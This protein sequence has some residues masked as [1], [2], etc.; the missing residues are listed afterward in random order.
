[1]AEL[2]DAQIG[3]YREQGW[4]APIDIMSEAEAANILAELENAEARHP[5]HLHAENRNNAHL[6]FPFLSD[7]ALDPRIVDAAEQ[8]VGP[9]IS[10]WSTVL[11]IKE[12]SSGAFVSWHQDA[13]YM[14]LEPANFV[15]A[16]IALTPSTRE[17]G[18]VSVIPGTYLGRA[19]HQ[20]EYGDDNILTRGQTIGGVD[21]SAAV[22]LVLRPGQMSLHHPWLIHGSQPNRSDRRRVGIAMQSYL[23]GDV[24][25]MRGEHHVVAVRGATP[26]SSFTV[27]PTPSNPVDEA[28]VAVRSAANDAFS[29]VLYDGAEQR[30]SL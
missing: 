2:S 11:F 25:P 18:C 15:T 13:Y 12:P 27:V 10:L 29:A 5:D 26:H 3:Q 7:L 8:L 22:D 23:G 16:W 14:A 30:R 6:S 20:D 28:A 1:M 19:D 17:S 4:I 9:D 21:E 24:R